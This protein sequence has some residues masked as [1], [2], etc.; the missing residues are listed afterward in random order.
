[1]N[2]NGV[3]TSFLD[4]KE[5]F[6][7][8]AGVA[9]IVAGASLLMANPQTRQYVKDGLRAIFPNTD[10]DKLEDPLAMGLSTVMP[11]L[12]RYLKLRSM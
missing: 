8:A 2:G 11:D 7:T 10:F 4:N 1:M 3:G 9:M 12:E 5:L 6:E